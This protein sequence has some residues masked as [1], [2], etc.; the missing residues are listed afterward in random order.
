[1]SNLQK[2]LEM[3]LHDVSE[4]GAEIPDDVLEQFGELCKN[5]LKNFYE[6]RVVKT[7]EDFSASMSSL[8]R[9]LCQQQLEKAGAPKDKMHYS[10]K[11]KFLIGDVVEAAVLA[12]IKMSPV[13]VEEFQQS[14]EHEVGGATI[15]GTLDVVLDGKVYDIKSASKYS[16]TSK[17]ANPGGFVKLA[18]DDPFGYMT[19]GYMYSEAVKKPFGG[20]IAVNKETGEIAVLEP[21]RVDEKYKKAALEKAKTN[22]VAL[23]S[24]AP[25]K[26]CYELEDETF[27]KKSTGNK[28]LPVTCAYCVFKQGCWDN[29]IKYESNPRSKAMFPRKHWYYGDIK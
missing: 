11:L 3:Y 7:G 26:R 28:I 5:S 12:I 14:V 6:K 2:V 18:E 8:G 9:P 21:P 15:K 23:N 25:F 16:F 1:M 22:I 13:S 4:N 10:Q 19:Q 20:W 29:R 24:D 17:F 27:N